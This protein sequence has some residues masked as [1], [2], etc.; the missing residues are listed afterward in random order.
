MKIEK[1]NTIDT[2]LAGKNLVDV[3]GRVPERQ[4]LE[5]VKEKNKQWNVRQ[6]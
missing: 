1:Q 4:T 3:G 2:S 5:N 6:K